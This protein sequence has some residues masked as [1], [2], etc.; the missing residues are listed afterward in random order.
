MFHGFTISFFLIGVVEY[1]QKQ[2]PAFLRTTAQGLILSFHFGAGL[3]I[4]NV[5]IGFLKDRIGMQQVMWI[6][7]MLSVFVILISI[8]IFKKTRVVIKTDF[9]GAI[10]SDNRK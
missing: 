2:T 4:G 5:W 6:Q 8:L 9:P 10:I 7:S 3:A 1:V